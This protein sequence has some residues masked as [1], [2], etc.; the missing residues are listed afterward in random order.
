[1]LIAAAVAS[2]PRVLVADEPCQGLDAHNRARVLG[3]LQRLGESGACS[4]VY[5][6][7]HPEETL[8][9]ISH[10]LHLRDGAAMYIGEREQ[11][12]PPAPLPGSHMCYTPV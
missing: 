12:R 2:R 6:T 1:V 3:L 10:V 8:P 7:H 11:Y 5:I 4:L 9:C